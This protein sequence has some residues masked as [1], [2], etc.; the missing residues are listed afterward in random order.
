[1]L[2]CLA[3]NIL[4]KGAN[5]MENGAM[6]SSLRFGNLSRAVD[7]RFVCGRAS[8]T[9]NKSSAD[10]ARYRETKIGFK[11][12]RGEIFFA[13]LAPKKSAPKNLQ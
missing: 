10:H 7:G 5:Q 8:V 2:A 4:R 3:R 13:Y 9:D 11:L 1:M 6:Q 12:L